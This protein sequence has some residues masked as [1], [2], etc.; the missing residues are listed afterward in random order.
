MSK[1]AINDRT[2]GGLL[3]LLLF[4][5]LYFLKG[6]FSLSAPDTHLYGS[7]VFVE[8]IGDVAHPGVYD[9]LH[10]PSLK[11]LLRRAGGSFSTAGNGLPSAQILHDSGAHVEVRSEGQGTS[12]FGGEMGAFYKITLGIPICINKEPL[13]GLTAVPG[14]GPALANAIVRER[15]RNGGFQ[16]LDE[17][18]AIR[19]IGPAL[20]QKLT[21]HLTL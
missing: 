21:P 1:R 6:I 12:V 17:L 11:D 5:S 18:L 10:P 20:Y 2:A 19:G 13:E 7:K 14:I 9:F 15:A 8:I 16:M 4:L 3:L